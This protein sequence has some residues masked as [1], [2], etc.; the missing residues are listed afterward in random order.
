M[1]SQHGFSMA[2]LELLL[3]LDLVLVSGEL[4]RE[5]LAPPWGWMKGQSGQGDGVSR[6][7]PR[8]RRDLG[9]GCS[10]L[11]GSWE[12]LWPQAIKSALPLI[13]GRLS[14]LTAVKNS[15]NGRE[16]GL[17]QSAAQPGFRTRKG[18]RLLVP[19]TL[20]LLSKPHTHGGDASGGGFPSSKSRWGHS[21]GSLVGWAG[22]WPVT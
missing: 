18:A 8:L 7:V 15:S 21:S 13:Q 10:Q 9:L 3:P 6:A 20:F 4:L 11:G 5:G 1:G 17:G 19:Q 2:A 14:G 22:P 12:S 16:N